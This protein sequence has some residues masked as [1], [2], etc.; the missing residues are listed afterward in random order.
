MTASAPRAITLLF[1]NVVKVVV[2]ARGMTAGRKDED[3]EKRGYRKRCR[4]S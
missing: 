2:K 1:V 4:E 3:N